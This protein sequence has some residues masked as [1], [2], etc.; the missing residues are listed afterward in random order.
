MN[1]VSTERKL[2]GPVIRCCNKLSVKAAVLNDARVIC[3]APTSFVCYPTK[4]IEWFNREQ[5]V[6]IKSCL[7]SHPPLR[8]P[9]Q[10]DGRFGRRVL[11]EL[12]LAVLQ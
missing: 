6:A 1:Y 2:N 3:H 10:G 5:T 12:G 11:L 7:R 8:G 4:D 9:R